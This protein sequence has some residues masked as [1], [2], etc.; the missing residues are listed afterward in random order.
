MF[1]CVRVCVPACLRIAAVFILYIAYV[2]YSDFTCAVILE[3][4]GVVCVK[5][6]ESDKYRDEKFIRKNKTDS[7]PERIKD[8]IG[9]KDLLS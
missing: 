9:T 8:V 1:T 2:S 7:V 6:A 3:S 4:D 5:D